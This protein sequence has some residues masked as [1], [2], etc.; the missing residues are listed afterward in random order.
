MK[1]S[2]PLLLAVGI[3]LCLSAVACG[4][5]ADAPTLKIAGIPD[6]NS[7]EIARRYEV[8][9]T[10][11]SGELG[12]EVEFV[13]TVNYAATV[14]GFKQGGIQLAWFGGLTGV[15]ARKAVPG[16]KAIAQRPRDAEFH[17]KFIVAADSEAGDI[18]DLKDLT[19]T[20]GSE[21]STSGHLMP[22]HFLLKIG[23]DP[24]KDFRG[25]PNYSGSHDK[26]WKLVESG[27]FQAGALNEAVW[28]QA[29]S[30]GKV[31][32]KKVRELWVTPPYYD[33][34]WTVRGD[35]DD[36]FGHGFTDRVQEAL[37]GING[38]HG[39]IREMFQTDSFEVSENANYRFIEEI[40][41]DLGIL[42]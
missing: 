22:R 37:L 2:K 7:S 18:R 14:I 3:L 41:R 16:S 28:D 42:N 10:Y 19:F 36:K 9:T 31:D 4:A 34:N 39:E 11:L 6:Q 30:E 24:D 25:P 33:Y 17:S 35:L 29:V 13:P 20:F 40:A 5:G 8:L 32:L 23:I 1:N 21:S 27:A 26:T 12:V 38:K 15:Q